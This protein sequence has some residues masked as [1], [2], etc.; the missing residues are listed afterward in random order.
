MKPVKGCGATDMRREW[1]GLTWGAGREPGTGIQ[2]EL[3]Y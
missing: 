2:E 1:K 3:K